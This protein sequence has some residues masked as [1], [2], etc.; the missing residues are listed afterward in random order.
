MLISK[1]EG[2]MTAEIMEGSSQA[3]L[4]HAEL[5][6]RAVRWLRK[7]AGCGVALSEMVSVAG[8]IPDAIGWRSGFS[9]LIEAKTSR[10]DF[11]ADR[12]K[13]WRRDPEA[14]MGD[15]RFFITPA[16]LLLPAEIPDGWGLLEVDGKCVLRTHRVPKGNCWPAP[17]NI[18][19]KRAETILLCS[20]MR[21]L[22]EDS[23]SRRQNLVS[24]TL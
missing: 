10:A 21:R 8:E 4:L 14:G 23:I 6:A 15:W 2:G 12:K 18:G 24:K 16:G 17:P 11:F 20:A 1:T 5:C 13:I 19:N 9:V 3:A 22:T 7:S